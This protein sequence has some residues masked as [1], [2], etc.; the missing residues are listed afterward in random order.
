[1]AATAAVYVQL[2]DDAR[3]AEELCAAAV[4]AMSSG[5]PDPVVEYLVLDV[6]GN[7]A[8]YHGDDAAAAELTEKGAEIA[9]SAGLLYEQASALW[10]GAAVLAVSDPDRAPRLARESVALARQLGAP[11]LLGLCL[12]VL[13][14]ALAGSD[15]AEARRLSRESAD[16]IAALPDR[17][18]PDPSVIAFL[19][20]Q[21]EDWQMVLEVAP[22][23]IRRFHW[24]GQRPSQ[25]GMF[26]MVSRALA[27]L[28]AETAALLQGG[29]R[30]MLL[31]LSTAAGS[32]MPQEPARFTASSGGGGLVAGLRR[33]TTSILRDALG[34]AHLRE[35]RS[36]GEAMDDD[37]AVAL[38]L[39]AIARARSA[40]P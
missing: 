14:T 27:P 21:V 36:A 3:R 6:R 26:N 32:N 16:V 7:L 15:P 4:A 11:L 37:H 5:E 13:S 31:P 1:M 19:A 35:L 17:E 12:M 2:T 23:A 30:R 40:T 39:D 10:A 28:D 22:D 8:D 20:A 24:L 18:T 38:I 25:A 9:R 34:E 33:Q 29:A